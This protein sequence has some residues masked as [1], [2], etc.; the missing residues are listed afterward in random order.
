MYFN[1]Y[2]VQDITVTDKTVKQTKFLCT[3]FY[4]KLGVGGKDMALVH[5]FDN[6]CVRMFYGFLSRMLF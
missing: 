3:M 6:R 1:V 4:I 5:N 2:V